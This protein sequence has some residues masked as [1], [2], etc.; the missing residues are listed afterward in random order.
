MDHLS[1]KARTTLDLLRDPAFCSLRKRADQ[2]VLLW[3]DFRF[4]P[5]PV[6]YTPEDTWAILTTMRKQVSLS[7]PIRSYVYPEGPTEVWYLINH[8]MAS[9]ISALEASAHLDEKENL[10]PDHEMD[11]YFF[12]PRLALD[13]S[14]AAKRDEVDISEECILAL[15]LQQHRPVA[16]E[17]ILIANAVSLLMDIE[18]HVHHRITTWVLDD[19]VDRLSEGCESLV[20]VDRLHRFA[21]HEYSV[22]YA[23]IPPEEILE[24]I[25]IIGNRERASRLSHPLIELVFLCIYCWDLLPLR[26]WNG[27]AEVVLRHIMLIKAGYPLLRWVPLSYLYGQWES[28][29]IAPPDVCG[30]HTDYDPDIGEGLDCTSFC[31][32]VLQLILIGLEQLLADVETQKT[33]E[34]PLVQAVRSLGGLNHRQRDILTNLVS[35][36]ELSLKINPHQK[37]YGV[38]YGTARSDFLKLVDVGLLEQTYDGRAMVFKKGREFEQALECYEQLGR[39][40]SSAEQALLN[41]NARV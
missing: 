7:L 8:A 35:N 40:I 12:A 27:I 6:G 36:P 31:H 20:C 30:R 9:T 19:I 32:A 2:D 25:C 28:G 26:K 29:T 37:L 10:I 23:D 33:S 17:E 5:M 16:P 34:E 13:L 38:A 18:R 39:V 22:H 41:A 3:N 11:R 24:D 21:A 1:E 14:Y 15:I 4:L